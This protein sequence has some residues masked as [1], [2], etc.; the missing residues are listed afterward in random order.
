MPTEITAIV[1]SIH[2]LLLVA[3]Q[4]FGLTCL[5]LAAFAWVASR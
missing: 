4:A 5:A 2:S 3:P 1:A